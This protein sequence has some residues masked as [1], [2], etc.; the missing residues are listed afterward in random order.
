MKAA[1]NLVLSEEQ[2][3]ALDSHSPLGAAQ[4]ATR[5]LLINAVRSDVPTA[6]R[7]VREFMF[8]AH[9]IKGSPFAEHM[10]QK[11]KIANHAISIIT[12][13]RELAALAQRLGVPIAAIGE[14][15]GQ[16]V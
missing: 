1:T 3:A 11:R 10:V 13:W 8:S 2:L 7:A 14:R 9:R 15:L 12:A 16:D 5:Q 4:R 6:Q